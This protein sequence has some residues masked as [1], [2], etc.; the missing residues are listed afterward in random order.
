MLWIIIGAAVLV[1]F[2]LVIV[3]SKSGGGGGRVGFPPGTLPFEAQFSMDPL[4]QIIASLQA[5][6]EAA[7]PERAVELD[8]EIAFLLSQAE[9]MKA[10]I[11]RGELTE[12]RGYIGFDTYQSGENSWAK[13]LGK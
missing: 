3:L 8:L 9:E 6:R 13:A 7:D 2:I 4:L 10:I 12:G 1:V 5:E 11:A